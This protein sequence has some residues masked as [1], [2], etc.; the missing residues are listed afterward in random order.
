MTDKCTSGKCVA[1]SPTATPT[2]APGACSKYPMPNGCSCNI[3]S[4]CSSG[5][6]SEAKKCENPPSPSNKCPGAEACPNSS[7]KN[8][9]QNCTP[10]DSDG[11]PKDSL[12][13]KAGIIEPCGGKNYCC[14][15]A[16]GAWT[17]DM[18]KCPSA[19]CTQCSGKPQ[20]KSK[21]DADCSG[22]TTLNDYS[23][24]RS[25]FISGS[26]GT[27]VKIDWRADFDCDGKVT[28]N[29]FSIWRENFVKSL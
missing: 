29:D 8:L 18:T 5:Y 27:G 16:G 14:P 26:L 24:W 4:Q 12:C 21:G 9:L 19:K 23:I 2:N 3:G 15:S 7:N 10:P 20:A 6:C 13:N 1:P 22:T 11:T 17:T 25:E 28:L